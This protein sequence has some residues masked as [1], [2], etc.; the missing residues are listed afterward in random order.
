[1]ALPLL[2]GALSEDLPEPQRPVLA[3]HPQLGRW[4]ALL[5]RGRGGACWGPWVGLGSV[6]AI[7]GP[8][9]QLDPPRSIEVPLWP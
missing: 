1:M 3:R 6:L 9:T 7:L 4:A 8:L 2:R 5:V